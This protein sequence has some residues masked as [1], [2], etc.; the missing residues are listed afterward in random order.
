MRRSASRQRRPDF[1]F[2]L[3]VVT[4]IAWLMSLA[5]QLGDTEL[6]QHLGSAGY[7]QAVAPDLRGLTPTP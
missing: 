2:V 4:G 3:V 7:S 5:V 6:M 1:L